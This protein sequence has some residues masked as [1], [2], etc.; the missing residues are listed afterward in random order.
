[1]DAT[2]LRFIAGRVKFGNATAGA[3]FPSVIAV[4]GTPKVPIISHV[5]I[6]EMG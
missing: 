3:P 6:G 1:M 5:R 4:F 2:E